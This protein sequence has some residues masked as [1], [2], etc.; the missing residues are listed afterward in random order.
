MKKFFLLKI[1]FLNFMALT[2]VM[3]YEINT[4]DS[5]LFKYLKKLRLLYVVPY[6][7]VP[8]FG[9]FDIFKSNALFKK[10]IKY[11]DFSVD[12]EISTQNLT[13][14]NEPFTSER[15]T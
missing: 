8:S 6:F 15:V 4:L 5:H 11:F 13:V 9:S 7:V 3:K 12:V 1:N 10:S 2:K 14:L